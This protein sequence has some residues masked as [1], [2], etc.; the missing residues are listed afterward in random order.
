VI[1]LEGAEM[2]FWH[3]IVRESTKPPPTLWV[4][5]AALPSCEAAVCA[6][7]FIGRGIVGR[8]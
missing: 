8:A 7:L 6:F 4:K 2:A 3:S 1:E 5:D